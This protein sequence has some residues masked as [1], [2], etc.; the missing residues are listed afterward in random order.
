[1]KKSWNFEQKPLKT[2]TNL[3]FLTVLTGY[4]VKYRFET[5]IYRIDNIFLLKKHLK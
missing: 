5:K 2:W 3:Q 1:M 4:V